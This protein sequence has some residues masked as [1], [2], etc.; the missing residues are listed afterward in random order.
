MRDRMAVIDPSMLDPGHVH[1]L[2]P[3]FNQIMD[4][5]TTMGS[6]MS[7]HLG[8]DVLHAQHGAES[9]HELHHYYHN[10]GRHWGNAAK[11]W[12]SDFAQ[13]YGR[14]PS[15]DQLKAHA[16]DWLT[17]NAMRTGGRR[18]AGAALDYMREKYP[19]IYGPGGTATTSDYN[20]TGSPETQYHHRTSPW[21]SESDLIDEMYDQL[22]R[23]RQAGRES[24][25]QEYR[26][27]RHRQEVELENLTGGHPADIA[28]YFARGGKPLIT[29]KDWVRGHK[30]INDPGSEGPASHEV[31]V[32]DAEAWGSD[33][34]TPVWARDHTAYLDPARIPDMTD[35]QLAYLRQVTSARRE[36]E[37]CALIQDEIARRE[38]LYS[39]LA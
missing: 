25:L 1:M 18:E 24:D 37:L 39:M 2:A 21:A 26:N 27:E 14:L 12:M 38:L 4:H 13:Q 33:D 34:D 10:L 28:D 15:V 20:F 19:E 5:L 7:G 30:G 35:G 8:E 3:V 6:E 16:H 23:E 36:R 29:Y 9:L 31:Y 11:G 32:P 17:A 22:H